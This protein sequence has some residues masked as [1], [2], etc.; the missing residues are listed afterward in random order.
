MLIIS[1]G[2]AEQDKKAGVDP[3]KQRP[4]RIDRR[5]RYPL[6][7]GLHKPLKR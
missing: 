7:D 3:P 2:H 5:S 6:E 1:F 4:V